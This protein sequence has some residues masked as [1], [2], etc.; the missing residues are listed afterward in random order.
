M[1]DALKQVLV[2]LDSTPGSSIRL[3]AARDIAAQHG[4]A[5]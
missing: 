2:H 4:S 1:S 5:A 3:Q